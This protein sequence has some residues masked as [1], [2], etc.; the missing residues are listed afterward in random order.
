MY[1][2][3]NKFSLG[4]EIKIENN[5]A[6]L[7]IDDEKIIVTNDY[8]ITENIAKINLNISGGILGKTYIISAEINARKVDFKIIVQEKEDE[9]NN[10]SGIINDIIP[11]ESP[12]NYVQSYYDNDRNIVIVSN[13]ITN[14]QLIPHWL[15]SRDLS[16][17]SEKYAFYSIVADELSRIMIKEK[18]RKDKIAAISDPDELFN[19]LSEE[20]NIMYKKLLH[21]FE[22]KQ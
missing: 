18:R 15:E 11:K 19:I 12:I 5:N 8:L 20:K 10:K 1:V 13:N 7:V 4:S 17:L 2:D 22:E 9:S 21:S 16:T 14:K 6:D 3:T